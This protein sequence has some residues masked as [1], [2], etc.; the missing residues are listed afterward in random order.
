MKPPRRPRFPNNDTDDEMLVGEDAPDFPEQSNN[1][2]PRRQTRVHRF[3][4]VLIFLLF[5]AFILKEQVPAVNDAIESLLHPDAMRAVKACRTAALASSKTPDFV[6]LI[7]L[8][9]ASP[10]HNGFIIEQLVLGEMDPHEGETQTSIICH[11]DRQG[12]VI[13]L[14][15]KPV[16][17][18]MLPAEVEEETSDD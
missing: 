1:Y 15:R 3:L 10:T 6:R 5:G 8:G 9:R 13:N 12:Q 16:A 7:K 17:T 14:A 11:I 2:P 4:P 18:R